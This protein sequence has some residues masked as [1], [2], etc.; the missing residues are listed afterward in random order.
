M[1]TKPKKTTAL[2]LIDKNGKPFRS[3]GIDATSGEVYDHQGSRV[4]DDGTPYDEFAYMTPNP[5]ETP[6][7]FARRKELRRQGIIA[8][9]LNDYCS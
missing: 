4:N 6:A 1:K 2:P 5:G 9:N 3:Y 7:A 8:Q